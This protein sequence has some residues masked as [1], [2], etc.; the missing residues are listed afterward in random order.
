MAAKLEAQVKPSF[1]AFA[2]S[3]VDC[4]GPFETKQGRGKSRTKRYLCLFTFLQTRCVHLELAYGLDTDS[5]LRALDRFVARRGVPDDMWSDNGT[6]F[7]RAD[8]EIRQLCRSLDE[9]KVK[10]HV[11]KKNLKWHFNPP[12]APHFGGAFEALV[13]LVKRTLYRTLSDASLSDEELQTACCQAEALINSRPLTPLSSDSKDSPPLTPAHFLI[14]NVRTEL[15]PI[16]DGTESTEQKRWR[17]LQQVSLAFWGRWIKEYLPLLQ[18]RNKWTEVR[19]DLQEGDVVLVQNPA[20][21]RG[22][23]PLGRVTRTFK[24]EDDRVRV[25]EVLTKGKLMKRPVVKLVKLEVSR[26]SDQ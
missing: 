19:P 20:A 26:P 22:E 16:A 8:R 5:F 13:K 25:V 3:A 21:P 15:D 1:R 12:G 4:A 17:R 23:W 18:P 14:G 7:V 11:S 6:N 9:E 24:G 10:K 2:K